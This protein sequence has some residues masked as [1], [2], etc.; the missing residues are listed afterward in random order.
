ME[1]V[2]TKEDKITTTTKFYT[3]VTTGSKLSILS[4]TT[5]TS[6][7]GQHPYILQTYDIHS[8]PTTKDRTFFQWHVTFQQIHHEKPLIL[9]RE[10][11]AHQ[12]SQD[13]RHK[14][15]QEKSQPAYWNTDPSTENIGTCHLHT[16][17]HQV[18]HASQQITHQCSQRSGWQDTQWCHHIFQNHQFNIY[19]H[20]LSAHTP[21]HLLHSG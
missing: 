9:H 1:D 3:M 4:I 21:S 19:P 17:C 13:Q 11:L 7:L 10:R 5:R 14:E 18:C 6:Q 12:D 8:D 20:K 16:R 15:H 2:Y